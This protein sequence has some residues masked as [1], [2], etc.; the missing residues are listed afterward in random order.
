[1]PLH[2]STDPLFAADNVTIYF[3][4]DV[5]GA[6][7]KYLRNHEVQFLFVPAYENLTLKHIAAYANQYSYVADYLPDAPDIPKTP[8]QFIVN[9][10]AAV[11]GQPFRDWVAN[12]I[13]ERNA[14]MNDKKEVM[15]S[16]DPSMAAKFQK[17]THV[18]SKC[19]T[20]Q[21]NL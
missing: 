9:V 17:S 8:K 10:C 14:I 16:I 5:I 13:E 6:K 4:K 11:I 12:Q 1:M 2:H 15:I 19:L 3:L 7:K 21:S 18:S 20:H